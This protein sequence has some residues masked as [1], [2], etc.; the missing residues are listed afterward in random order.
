MKKVVVCPICQSKNIHKSFD[1]KDYFLTQEKFS[2]WHCKDCDL[3]FTNPRPEDKNL[4]K[5]YESPEYLSHDTT[6][7][8][9]TG[10]LYKLLRNINIKRK[11]KIVSEHIGAGKILDIGCGTG[12]LLSYFQKQNWECVGVEPNALARKFAQTHYRLKV[13]AEPGLQFMPTD[14]FDIISMWHVLEHVSDINERMERVKQLLKKEGFLIVALPNL[15]SWDAGFYEAYWAGLDVPRHLSHF[16]PVA[17]TN[18]AKK[19]DLQIVRTLPLKFDAFYVSLLSERYKKARLPI[20]RA[21]ING[22]K[23]NRIAAKTGNYSSLIFVLKKI[24]S[25]AKK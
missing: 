8:G 20:L 7:S 2:V 13:E 3:S 25:E 24:R 9:A 16:S 21:F 6:S 19:H 10:R 4:G 14:S 1:V 15:S 5:Y 22:T 12:E 18:L 23:S 17:F 11:Y